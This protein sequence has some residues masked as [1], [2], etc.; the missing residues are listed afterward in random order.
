MSV[1]LQSYAGPGDKGLR[2]TEMEG[3]QPVSRIGE[4]VMNSFVDPYEFTTLNDAIT[5]AQLSGKGAAAPQDPMVEFKPHFHEWATVQPGMICLS[6]KK[7]TAVFRQ[8]VAAETA[9]PVIACAACLPAVNE[10]DFFF[11]GV[12]RSKSVR[13][14]DDGIGPKVDEFFTVSIG[15]MVTVLNTAGQPIHPGDLVEWCFYPEK[16]THSGKRARQGPRRVGITIAS[17][18]SPKIIGRAISFAKAGEQL[19]LLLKC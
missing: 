6:R 15:G 1:D 13:E 11:A 12:A 4:T 9:A 14:A 18:S 17:V 5:Q 16:G 19:D 2:N 8:F 3:Y 10:K 7:R